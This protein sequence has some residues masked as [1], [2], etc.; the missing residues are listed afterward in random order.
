[1]NNLTSLKSDFFLILFSKDACLG[2]PDQTVPF[3][4]PFPLMV[5]T[6]NEN[7]NVVATIFDVAIGCIVQPTDIQICIGVNNIDGNLKMDKIMKLY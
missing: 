7:V 2:I 3:H 1:M 4:V 6:V 5:M